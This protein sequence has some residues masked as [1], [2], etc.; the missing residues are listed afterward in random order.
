MRGF[1]VTGWVF[2][3]RAHKHSPLPTCYGAAPVSIWIG[4]HQRKTNDQQNQ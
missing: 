3:N 2:A 4:N 1:T